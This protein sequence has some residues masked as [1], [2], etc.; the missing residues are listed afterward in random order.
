[1]CFVVGL[2]TAEA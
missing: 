2:P 1:M